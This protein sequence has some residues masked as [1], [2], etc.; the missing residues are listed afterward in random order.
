MQNQTF[1]DDSECSGTTILPSY[2]L[3]LSPLRSSLI[4]IS[5]SL[6]SSRFVSFR[7]ISFHLISSH[8]ISSHLISSPLLSSPLLSSPLLSYPLIISS[9]LLSSPLLSYPLIISSSLLSFRFVSSHLISS[10]LIS[11]HLI[12]SHLISSHLI[13]SHLLFLSSLLRLEVKNRELVRS[14]FLGPQ[15]LIRL[16]F[17]ELLSSALNVL[18]WDC[19]KIQPRFFY[20]LRSDWTCCKTY[21]LSHVLT[22]SSLM[23]ALSP[24]YLRAPIRVIKQNKLW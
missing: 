4:I 20:L 10:H 15:K 24:W 2:A 1:A 17:S 21:G 23:Y 22:T 11:S 3:V 13:S 8:L 18:L 6:L 7:F 5:S 14:C 12:S 9:P 19:W 16:A